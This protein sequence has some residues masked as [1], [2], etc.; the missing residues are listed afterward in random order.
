M[1]LDTLIAFF[2]WCSIINGSILLLWTALVLFA[3][4]LIYQLHANWFDISR[5][6]YNKA[7]Y[8][9]LG[10]FKLAYLLLNLVP[11]IALT[12]IE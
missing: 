9:F 3:S 10:G 6:Q 7:M 12:L 11:F 8:Y 1:T 5:E 2:M 4:N